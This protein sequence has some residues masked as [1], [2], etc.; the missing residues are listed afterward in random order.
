MPK[1]HELFWKIFARNQIVKIS[2]TKVYYHVSSISKEIG[3]KSTFKTEEERKGKVD[4]SKKKKSG[5]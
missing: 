5:V 2:I 3:Y 4:L 1:E